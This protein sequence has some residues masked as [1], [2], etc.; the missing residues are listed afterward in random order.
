[1]HLHHVGRVRHHARLGRLYR[2][3]AN[4]ADRRRLSRLGPVA[5]ERPNLR[6]LR[7]HLGADEPF[8]ER[9]RHHAVRDYADVPVHG[10]SCESG[11]HERVPDG[12]HV[13]VHELSE[14]PASE[15]LA[16]HPHGACA[17]GRLAASLVIGGGVPHEGVA[18]LVHS[19]RVGRRVAS[20]ARRLLPQPVG[21]LDGHLLR[22]VVPHRVVAPGRAERMLLPLQLSRQ[23]PFPAPISIVAVHG[24]AHLAAIVP[25]HHSALKCPKAGTKPLGWTSKTARQCSIY[26]GRTEGI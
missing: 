5:L 1:M 17:R 19:P 3:C 11:A 6:E 13:G 24:A 7:L 18:E 8:V 15:H 21:G 16:E 22:P 14:R 2:L 25:V 20:L 4:G 12:E 23:T 9:P 10:D 26:N